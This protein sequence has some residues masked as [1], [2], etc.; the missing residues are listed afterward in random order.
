VAVFEP[1]ELPEPDELLSELPEEPFDEGLASPEL[2]LPELVEVELDEPPSPELLD[3]FVSVLS[4]VVEV[5]VELDE[6]RLSVL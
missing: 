4:E 5:E 1:D 3:D 6:P 2:P